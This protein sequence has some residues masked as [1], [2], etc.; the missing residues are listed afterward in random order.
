MAATIVINKVILAN[1]GTADIYIDTNLTENGKYRWIENHYVD[2]P[3]FT[4][5]DVTNNGFM[6]NFDMSLD[7]NADSFKTLEKYQSYMKQAISELV[8]VD[9]TCNVLVELEAAE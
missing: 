4:G 7:C 8:P 3:Y 9:W 1:D 5:W 2:K 6:I